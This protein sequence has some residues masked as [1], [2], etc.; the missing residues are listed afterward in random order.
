MKSTTTTS[1]IKTTTNNGNNNDNIINNLSP[2]TILASTFV[3]GIAIGTLSL[4]S[5]Q[6]IVRSSGR[7]SG[8]GKKI[9]VVLSGAGYLDGSEIT[10]TVGVL[11]SLAECGAE[12]ICFAPFNSQTDVVDHNDPSTPKAFAPRMCHQEAARICRGGVVDLAKLDVNTYDGVIFPGG[13]GVAKSLSSWASEGPKCTL[14]PDVVRVIEGFLSAKKPIGCCCIA[15]VLGAKVVS[16]LGGTLRLTLGGTG[17]K[18]PYDGTIDAIKTLP[19][20]IHVNA[21]VNEIVIDEVHKFVSTPAYMSDSKPDSI[22]RGVRKL[23][24]KV[25]SM[26]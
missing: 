18:W 2:T 24:R 6:A 19:G 4:L 16:S 23:V 25:I 11:A 9:A 12:A 7:K 8:K 17:P 22:I 3:A 26:T 1:T 14:N 10:E 13:F 5:V 20:I 15:P 21:E